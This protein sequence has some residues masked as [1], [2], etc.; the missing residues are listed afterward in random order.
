MYYQLL[1]KFPLLSLKSPWLYLSCAGFVYSHY[2]W[3]RFFTD[4]WTP[5][6][7]FYQLFGFFF[8]C[9]WLVPGALFITLNLSDN[10]LPGGVDH[11]GGMSGMG[12]GMSGSGIGGHFGAFSYS[13]S[14]L[15]SSMVGGG[16][17]MGGNVLG[18]GSGGGR[19]HNNIISWV[20][21]WLSSFLS[22]SKRRQNRLPSHL[23]GMNNFGSD[24]GFIIDRDRGKH[25]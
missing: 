6:F 19:R 18:G 3:Y 17:S 2:T 22:K 1:K 7:D 15:S 4:P 11:L 21:D 13:P 5:H 9:V 10:S 25:M 20:N 23:G 16:S 8:T 12:G 14:S 24:R